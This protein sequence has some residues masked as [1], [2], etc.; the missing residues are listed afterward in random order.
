MKNCRTIKPSDRIGHETPQNMSVITSQCAARDDV[1]GL[2]DKLAAP[3]ARLD[4]ELQAARRNPAR[5]AALRKIIAN[6]HGTLQ[7]QR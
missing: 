2:W 1:R 3:Q 7:H 6:L 4:C 5:I